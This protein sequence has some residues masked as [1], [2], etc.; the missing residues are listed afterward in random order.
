MLIVEKYG[1]TSLGD[2]GLMEKVAAHVADLARRGEQMVIVVSAQG[3]TTDVLAEKAQKIQGSSLRETDAL[4]ATGEMQ[5]ASLMALT[6]IAQGIE[7]VSL[8]GIQAGIHTDGSYGQGKILHI[9]PDR[10]RRELDRGN[11]VVVAGFQGGDSQGNIVTLGRGGSD[12][13]AVAL[14]AGLKAD[15]C[16]I[17]TDVEGIYDR[18]PNKD[19]R[20]KKYETISYGDM[21]MLI[22]AGAQVLHRPCVELARQQKI[23][24]W[25]GSAFAD[26][27]GT[28]VGLW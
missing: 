25:V 7:A 20:A 24:I 22:D 2:Q 26:A 11:V 17:F 14:A 18:D 19:P 4:L 23:P 3:H 16:R 15:S 9:D 12:T 8:N 10:I 5:S 1:G 21:L 6:L 13:T 28:I 27:P